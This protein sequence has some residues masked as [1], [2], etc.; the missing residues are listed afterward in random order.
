MITI[1]SSPR[2]MNG[3]F[4]IIQLNAFNNWKSL[5][6]GVEIMI[7]GNEEGVKEICEEYGFVHI[8]AVP[9]NKEG[10]P[11]VKDLF[12]IANKLARNNILMYS[13]ADILFEKNFLNVVEFLR[14]EKTSFLAVGQ[15]YDVN[16]DSSVLFNND[17][18][19]DLKI[20]AILHP[21]TAK[22]YFIFTKD[23]FTKSFF[24]DFVIARPG[25]DDFF[26]H[27]SIM[28]NKTIIDL[29]RVVDVFHQNH[30]RVINLKKPTDFSSKNNLRL[31]KRPR[32]M[33]ISTTSKVPYF[34][35]QLN[36]HFVLR[37]RFI[38]FSIGRLIKLF[39]F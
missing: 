10:L 30:H 38:W 5:D 24:R 9:L 17:W 14:K 6:S 3:L 23:Y 12:K 1:F 31:L 13:N 21:P 28:E 22:D 35:D 4:R 33:F 18:E 26:V 39:G 11:F 16:I 7:F 2:G 19:R 27:N 37:R 36:G 34:L 8:P 15:R 29:S 20:K 25:W 32:R